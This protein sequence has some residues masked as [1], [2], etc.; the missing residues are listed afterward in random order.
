[1]FGKFW[2]VVEPGEVAFV[3]TFGQIADRTYTP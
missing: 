1:M 2:F 3:K